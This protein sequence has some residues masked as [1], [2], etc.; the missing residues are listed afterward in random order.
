MSYLMVAAFATTHFALQAFR[1]FSKSATFDSYTT[2]TD[3][4][5]L[6]KIGS[7]I[8]NYGNFVLFLVAFVT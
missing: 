6:F 8:I 7:Y 2:H 1:Y 5:N 3:N 4:T